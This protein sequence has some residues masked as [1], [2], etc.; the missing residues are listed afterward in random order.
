MGTW[1]PDRVHPPELI[2]LFLEENFI[3]SERQTRPQKVLVIH[4]AKAKVLQLL[5]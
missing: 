5:I 1:Y 3:S 2:R 4:E